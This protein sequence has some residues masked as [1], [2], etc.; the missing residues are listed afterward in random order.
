LYFKGRCRVFSGCGQRESEKSAAGCT[1][2][3]LTALCSDI[4]PC[5]LPGAWMLLQKAHAEDNDPLQVWHPKEQAARVNL[6]ATRCR[7]Y[8]LN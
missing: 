3:R 6:I 2:T 1:T 7:F 5:H 4:G 8:A